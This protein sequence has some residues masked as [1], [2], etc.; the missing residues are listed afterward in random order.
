[1]AAFMRRMNMISRCEGIYR[2]AELGGE[3]H[4][5][6]YSY[7]MAICHNPGLSQERLAKHLCINKSS[8]T[9]HLAFLEQKGYVERRVSTEDRR[10]LLVYPT[11]AMEAMLPEVV[12]V[13]KKWNAQ[14]AQGIDE[15]ELAVFYRVLEQMHRTSMAIVYGSED[16]L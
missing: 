9:R 4:G 15:E 16:A 1:M 2:T 6:H 14:I 3:L 5:V 11:A 10:E 8:V 13:T 12:R 7:V